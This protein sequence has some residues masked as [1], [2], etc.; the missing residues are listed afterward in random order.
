M[1]KAI[2]QL[3]Q[4]CFFKY[5][6]DYSF[7]SLLDSRRMKMGRRRYYHLKPY[8]STNQEQNSMISITNFLFFLFL[9]F[10]SL[11]THTFCLI[12]KVNIVCEPKIVGIGCCN[13]IS[14]SLWVR[15]ESKLDYQ[16]G[17]FK[18]FTYQIDQENQLTLQLYGHYY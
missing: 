11:F 16:I 15:F 6:H 10:N 13:C 5:F 7:I 3:M 17:N 8:L 12:M 9:F 1:E 14:I 18:I 4:N 2:K